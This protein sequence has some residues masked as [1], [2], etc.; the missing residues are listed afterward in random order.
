MIYQIESSII[1]V[2]DTYR[3][4]KRNQDGLSVVRLGAHDSCDFPHDLQN[5]ALELISA[6]QE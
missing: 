1:E 6:P 2:Q 4:V 3:K 5:L